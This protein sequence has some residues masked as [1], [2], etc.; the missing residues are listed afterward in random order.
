MCLQFQE[1][2][3]YGKIVYQLYSSMSMFR[4]PSL[5]LG[6]LLDQDQHVQTIAIAGSGTV[7]QGK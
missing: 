6:G 5:S 2:L 4:T 1:P 7:S 3:L